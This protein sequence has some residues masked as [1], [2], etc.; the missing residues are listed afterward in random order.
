MGLKSRPL[1]VLLIATAAFAVPDAGAAADKDWPQFRGPTGNGIAADADP[2]IEW[3]ENRNI[4]WKVRVPGRGWSS[5]VVLGN[6]IW[7]T[8]AIEQGRRRTRIASIQG[9]AADHIS[10]KAI[11][12][13]R[14]SG[15]SLWQVALFE[16]D[17]P[18]PIH[19][20]N[21]FATPTAVVEPGRL[22]CDF[23]NFGTACVDAG[24]GKVLWKRRLPI[25]HHFGPG[26]SPVIYK[27]L[28]VLVR[29]G[30]DAQY[31]AALDK[32]TGKT[33]W[34]TDRP[35]LEGDRR[36]TKKSFSTPLVI[37][38]G[39]KTQMIV[40]AAQWLVSYD[41]ASGKE[42]WR[43]PHGRGFSI[44]PRPIF[45]H[46]MVYFTTG[47]MKPQLWAVRVDGQDK[48]AES[49][50]V[51][52]ETRW[53]P[54]MASPILVGD[55]IY[56]VSYAGIVCC[57]DARSG[58]LLWH[59]KLSGKYM[60]SP[61]CAGRRLYFFSMDGKGTVLKGGKQFTQLA[62]NQLDG[63]VVA[64]PAMI[65]RAIFLR[66]DTHLYCIEGKIEDSGK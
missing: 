32:K 31:L 29:D 9:W 12:L 41:P 17:K 24:T 22:Y 46:G 2:P 35:P 53:I 14:A 27:N 23:G 52:K 42:I 21:S 5:P 66:T 26:S 50:V 58:K 57:G 18:A 49:R 10:L 54:F 47:D 61:A 13:D 1:T 55:E 62:A 48:A 33:I 30:C 51:W 63:P 38:G 11:C 3:S 56:W 60:A 64:S 6:R 44:A 20:L 39:G 8:T 65:G 7:L 4:K 37:Q 15:K 40:P 25:D 45:G 59:K 19:E 43:M 34:K 16:I 36:D 28:L